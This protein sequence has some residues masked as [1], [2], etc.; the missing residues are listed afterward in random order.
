MSSPPKKPL[1]IIIVGGSLAALMHGISLHRLGHKI[2][3]LEQSPIAA[4]TSHMAGIFLS[5]HATAFVERIDRVR[6]I[7]LGLP[8]LPGR[9]T[10]FPFPAFPTRRIITSWGA[11]YFRLRANFDGVGSVYIPCPP[12]VVCLDGE[13]VESARGRAVY[14]HQQRVVDIKDGFEG[15]RSKVSVVVEDLARGQT[16]ILPADLVLGADG[17]QST[18]R[19]IVLGNRA[20]RHYSG[21][22]AWRGVV[23]E[24][25][26]S[27]GTREAFQANTSH[28]TRGKEYGNAVAYPIPGPTGSLSSGER[29]INFVWY[30]RIPPPLLA[31]IM[32]DK[33]GK[34]H[35][36]TVPQGLVDPKIW[37]QQATLGTSFFPPAHAEVVSKIT[38]PFIHAIVDSYPA[39][40]KASFLNN[41]VLL[42]G[43]ALAHLRPHGGYS[44]SL[45]ALEAGWV[46]ELVSGEIGIAEWEKKVTR[47][48]YLWWCRGIWYGHSL[49]RAGSVWGF[50]LSAL[51]YWG[52]VVVEVG[53]A[54]VGW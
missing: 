11:L 49:L 3:I 26:L 27:E 40:T 39:P 43:D 37:S 38:N 22:V 2:H 32:T 10:G 25:E 44:T 9:L 31:S 12:D 21:Y 46:G 7:P 48:V 51:W 15:D 34:Y 45:A 36:T 52:V 5:P 42:V 4:P 53:R 23:P 35:R 17:R 54:Y 33:N 13:D 24:S 29:S 14:E 28:V 19:E 20:Y 30:F 50:V 41:R 8:A 18:V 1:D 6:E 47:L 16:R